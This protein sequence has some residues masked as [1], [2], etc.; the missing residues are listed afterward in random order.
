MNSR[1]DSS[2]LHGV[3][4]ELIQT[5]HDLMVVNATRLRAEGESLGQMLFRRGVGGRWSARR[6]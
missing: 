2:L 5:G 1:Y 6:P 4:E 3:A